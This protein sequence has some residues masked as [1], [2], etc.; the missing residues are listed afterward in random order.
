MMTRSLKRT[1]RQTTTPA[2]MPMMTAELALT[3]AQGA[4]IATR[5]ASMPLHAMEMSGLPKRK[6]QNV[7][8]ATE[9]AHAARLVF[10]A[11]TEMRGSVAPRVEPGLKP[12]QPKRRRNPHWPPPIRNVSS[13]G[14]PPTF[15][16]AALTATAPHWKAKPTT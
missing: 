1:P 5:P 14:V 13:V 10:T 11:I 8:A 12:I 6:Y 7:I 15:S 4:V 2:R 16:G 3:K 9:P